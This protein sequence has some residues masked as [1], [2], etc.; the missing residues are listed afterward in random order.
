MNQTASFS[1][2]ESLPNQDS[3]LILLTLDYLKALRRTHHHPQQQQQ[4]EEEEK[5]NKQEQH[6]K[7]HL[8]DYDYMTLAIWA[9]TKCF[10]EPQDLQWNMMESSTNDNDG[11]YASRSY[12]IGNDPLL[13]FSQVQSRLKDLH[14][15]HPRRTVGK[16]TPH[17][18]IPTLD[19][20]EGEI[21]HVVTHNTTQSQTKQNI[22]PSSTYKYDDYHYSNSHRYYK[23]HG[24][25]SIPLTLPTIVQEGLSSLQAKTRMEAESDL[26]KEPMYMDFYQAVKDKGYFQISTTDIMIRKRNAAYKHLSLDKVKQDI[27]RDRLQKVMT[28]YRLKVAAAAAAAITKHASVSDVSASI[29]N[30]GANNGTTNYTSNSI[31]STTSTTSAITK[32]Y[33]VHVSKDT[34]SLP[35]V[36]TA[37]TDCEEDYDEE[38]VDGVHNGDGKDENGERNAKECIPTTTSGSTTTSATVICQSRKIVPLKKAIVSSVPLMPSSHKSSVNGDHDS[39]HTNIHFNEDDL[40]SRVSQKSG[41]SSISSTVRDEPEKVLQAEAFKAQGNECMKER[42]YEKAKHFY[43]QAIEVLPFGKTSHVYYCNRAAALLSMRNFS[44]A[45]FD[46]EQSIELKPRYSKAYCRLGL[47]NFFLSNYQEAIDAYTLALKYDPENAKSKTYLERSRKKLQVTLDAFPT[48][49]DK[50]TIESIKNDESNSNEAFQKS[51][52]EDGK[53]LTQEK[54]TWVKE[55]RLQNKERREEKENDVHLQEDEDKANRLKFEGNKAM[56]RKQYEEAISLYSQ[57]LRLSPAGP[58]SHIYYT[59]R[60][61]AYCHLGRYEDSESDAERALAL[62]PESSKAYSRLGLSRYFLRDYEGAVDAYESAVYHDPT[63]RVHLAYLEKA[64][65]KLLAI[66]S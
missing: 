45:V 43:T 16:L 18:V 38:E 53:H 29:S 64:R 19:I 34:M 24:L 40:C 35:S 14:A 3:C 15:Q 9:L 61:A 52:K 4:Q 28:K 31:A 32:K 65:Q 26:R 59:N 11:S 47:A 66:K 48:S 22:Q 41:R 62:E 17:I 58:S 56:A 2:S 57:A 37:S 25:D 23:H 54:A 10:K 44:E 7:T 51:L 33:M 55:W 1:P 50:L 39:V 36:P 46:A 49:N 42:K 8:F 5:N 20:M 30:T 60:S 12:K 63:N 13:S 6:H 21:L 27:H